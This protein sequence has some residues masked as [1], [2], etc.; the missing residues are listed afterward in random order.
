MDGPRHR[1][2]VSR[3]QSSGSRP[4][5][6]LGEGHRGHAQDLAG[7]QVKRPD[8]GHQDFH[9][10]RGFLFHDRAHGRHAVDHQGRVE[11]HA[12]NDRRQERLAFLDALTVPRN[13]E[14]FHVHRLSHL[15]HI[16]GADSPLA[17]PLGNYGV[18]HGA[19]DGA[20]H[21]DVARV[22]GVELHCGPAGRVFWDHQV[23]VQLALSDLVH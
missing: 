8:R 16:R 10:A 3:E 17:Q 6:I 2:A 7:E 9:D 4:N 12:R 14:Q 15:G 20:F 21:G 5:Q 22:P 23:T 1:R 11:Q 19:V 13:L 18:A